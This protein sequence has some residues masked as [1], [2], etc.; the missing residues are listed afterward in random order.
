MGFDPCFFWSNG[1]SAGRAQVF[2]AAGF[3][4]L[5]FLFWSNL[6]GVPMGNAHGGL[7]VPEW[8]T[9]RIFYV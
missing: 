5:S 2:C 7:R 6:S 3:S 1:I 9:S 4:L 8:N